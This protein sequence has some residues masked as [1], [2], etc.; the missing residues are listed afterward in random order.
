MESA[1]KGLMLSAGVILTCV[2]IGV[3]FYM[4]REAKTTAV[5]AGNQMSE[6]QKE[7]VE[8][9][10]TRYDGITVSGSDVLN[11]IKKNLGG[12]TAGKTGEV[13]VELKTEKTENTY[14]DSTYIKNLRDFADTR[15]V[16]PVAVFDA[17][18]IRDVNEVIV[19]IRFVQE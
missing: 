10:Y 18:I 9:N 13:Y 8:S 1:L 7:L 17:S 15:Y 19:G 4:A 14:V 11:F 5:Y 6:F 16:N 3:G 12:I 2:V